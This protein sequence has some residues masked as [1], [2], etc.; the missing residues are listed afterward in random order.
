MG[1]FHLD[2][3]GV[4]SEK[5]MY[6]LCQKLSAFYASTLLCIQLVV[7]HAG[8]QGGS[9]GLDGGGHVLCGGGH[10]RGHSQFDKDGRNV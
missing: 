9:V 5:C 8:R 2:R 6:V 1:M 4:Y 7:V 3:H 10:H